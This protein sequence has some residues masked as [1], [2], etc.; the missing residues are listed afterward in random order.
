MSVGSSPA[1]K[2]ITT[3]IG[4]FTSATRSFQRR[5]WAISFQLP[6]TNAA[7]STAMRNQNRPFR[8]C[9]GGRASTFDQTGARAYY[10]GRDRSEEHTSELQSLMRNPYAVFCLKKTNNHRQY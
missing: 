1:R 2:Q 5:T 6:N 10:G 7:R 4:S 9:I 8:N 3:R